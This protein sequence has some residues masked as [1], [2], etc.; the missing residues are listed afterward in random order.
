[1]TRP[2]GT[3]LLRG[4]EAIATVRKIAPTCALCAVMSLLS[5]CGAAPDTPTMPSS[6]VTPPAPAT[7]ILQ[8]IVK[9]ETYVNHGLFL[10]GPIS[11]AQV[12]VT[13]GPAAGQSVTT[14]AD[15]A[16]RFELPAGPFRVRWSAQGFEPRES[17]PGTVIAGSTTTVSAVILQLLANVIGDWSITGIVRDG[18]GN[19]IGGASIDD[20]EFPFFTDTV[21]RTDAAGRFV[22]TPRRE[23][24][25]VLHIDASKPGY[26]S[27][28]ITVP[29]VPS[30]PITADFRL[31]R[32]VR[33]WLDGPSTMQVGDVA[34][35]TAVIEYDDGSRTA[36]TPT[37]VDSSNPGVVR[38]KYEP[39]NSMLYVTAI[40]P[41]T[42]TLQLR[43]EPAAPLNV[44]VVP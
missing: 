24:S 13:E 8:G 31:L 3:T 18:V 16:Y 2:A 44:H 43:G 30:C 11:G 14:G 39:Q 7:G 6:A 38:A 12:V 36:F 41:G 25:P 1:M 32:V 17:D 40:A 34:P 37:F 28:H 5:A 42:A 23:H 33:E 21:A 20:V 19:P 9:H 22:L 26:R 15:G 35:A 29:C 27:Q 4:S 10:E